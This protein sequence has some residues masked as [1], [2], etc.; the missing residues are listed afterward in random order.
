MKMQQTIERWVIRDSHTGHL[1]STV[2]SRQKPGAGP[3][4]RV[5]IDLDSEGADLTAVQLYT[6]KQSAL[7][8][9]WR[10]LHLRRSSAVPELATLT[11]M[12]DAS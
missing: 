2:N 12:I 1:L 10:D 11:W 6:R 8:A 4:N 5:W 9:I 7:R 3:K